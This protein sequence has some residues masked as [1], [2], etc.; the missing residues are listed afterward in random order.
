MSPIRA[1]LATLLTAL[2]LFAPPLSASTNASATASLIGTRVVDMNGELHQI[3]MDGSTLKPSVIVFMS[4]QCAVD[5]DRRNQLADTINYLQRQNWLVYG[6][7]PGSQATWNEASRFAASLDAQFPII[8]DSDRNLGVSLQPKHA[9]EAIALS[10]LGVEL[11]RT[12][13][14]KTDLAQ[15]TRASIRGETVTAADPLEQCPLP[16]HALPEQVN[17]NR[18]VASLMQANCA[19][20]HRPKGIGPFPLQNYEQSRNL[21]PM[22]A[23]V[24]GKKIMPPWKALPGSGHYLNERLLSEHQIALLEQWSRSGAKE[25][26]AE[27]HTPPAKLSTSEWQLGE[28]DI[29]IEMPQAVDIPASGP[30]IY[31]YFVAENAIPDNLE[32]AAIDFLPGDASVVHHAN[33]F[34]D[35]GR[36]ARAMAAEDPEPGFSVFGTGGFFSY[37]DRDNTAAGLGAWAPGGNPIRYPDGVGIKLPGGAEFVFEIHYHPTGSAA[38][39]RSRLGIYLTEKPIKQPVTALFVGTNQVDIP[40]GEKNYQRHFWMELPADMRVVDIGPHMHY[41]GTHAKVTAT[42]PDG[43]KK[44]LL[45]V[46]WDFRWQGAYYYREPVFLPKGTRIDTI[47]SYDN[48]ADNPYNPYNPPV[49]ATWGWGTDQEMGEL[50][51]TALVDNNRDAQALQVAAQASWMRTSDP[52]LTQSELSVEEI[53]ERA[54]PLS[55]WDTDGESLLRLLLA[56]EEQVEA[57]EKALRAAIKANPR[58]AQLHTLYGSFLGLLAELSESSFSQYRYYTKAASSFEKA[59]ALDARQWDARFAL[60]MGAAEEDDPDYQRYAEEHFITL[61]E[62]QRDVASPP[63]RFALTYQELGDLYQRMGRK[64]DAVAIWRQGNDL[65]PGNQHLIERLGLAKKG[66]EL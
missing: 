41:L 54:K 43:T 11:F 20:C 30:E 33:F 21:A 31:R 5:A 63:V 10:K 25:G 22:I 8:L 66:V 42:L 46:N 19:D 39:D 55:T 32:I 23:Y 58:D 36:K 48:S 50:Y 60:A 37:W 27:E 3:G 40:P 28:P 16:A 12:N 2:S 24:T 49:R 64:R 57:S 29:I 14:L 52:L 17:Y 38:T 34:V 7:I 4:E 9:Y 65:F 13:S 61:I 56:S 53:I 45:E 15:A 26:S 35:Y 6:V 1:A 51:I 62:Q 59:L 44:S 18:H 47:T